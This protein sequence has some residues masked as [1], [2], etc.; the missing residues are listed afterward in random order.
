MYIKA[1]IKELMECSCKMSIK[2]LP[3]TPL[4][5]LRFLIMGLV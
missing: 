5:I 4:F 2:S 1:T 3:F